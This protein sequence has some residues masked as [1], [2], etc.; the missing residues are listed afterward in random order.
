L[1]ALGWVGLAL[2][3]AFEVLLALGLR[4]IVDADAGRGLIAHRP[5]APPSSWNSMSLDLT[6]TLVTRASV[7][8]LMAVPYSL[9]RLACRG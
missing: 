3:L 7:P 2:E 4:G 5:V 1:P 8:V 9:S 6:L